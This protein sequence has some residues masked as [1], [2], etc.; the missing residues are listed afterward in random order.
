M[1]E[2]LTI[3]KVLFSSITIKGNLLRRKPIV[4]EQLK[5]RNLL[6][7]TIINTQYIGTRTR[8]TKNR[9]K[10]RKTVFFLAISTPIWDNN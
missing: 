3:L 8:H 10:S 4:R 9:V 5:L 7:S 6:T 2:R 1:V